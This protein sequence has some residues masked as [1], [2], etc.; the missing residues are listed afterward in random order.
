MSFVVVL[1][2]SCLDSYVGFDIYRR[3]KLTSNFLMLWLSSDTVSSGHYL[4]TDLNVSSLRTSLHGIRKMPYKGDHNQQF[5]P[6]IMRVN[7]NNQHG[8]ISLRVQ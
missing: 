7:Y 5:Y 4:G 3:H 6:D 2:S 8:M 1:F